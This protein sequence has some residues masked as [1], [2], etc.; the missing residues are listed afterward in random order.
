MTAQAGTIQSTT[1]IRRAARGKRVL[2]R[3][4]LVI[5]KSTTSAVVFSLIFLF[6]MQFH[7]LFLVFALLCATGLVA[8][9]TA[10]RLL[11]AFHGVLQFLVALVALFAAMIA[12]NFYSGGVLGI[13]YLTIYHAEIDLQAFIQ[14]GIGLLAMLLALSAWRKPR[15]RQ[16][17]VEPQSPPRSFRSPEMQLEAQQQPPS[18]RVR[19]T[20]ARRAINWLSAQTSHP[21]VFGGSRRTP[22]P[23]PRDVISPNGRGL[24]LREGTQIRTRRSTLVLRRKKPVKFVGVEEH[25]CPYCL[26]TVAYNDPRGVEICSICHTHHH[27]DCWEVTGVCQVPH[28]NG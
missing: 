18:E 26:E 8:G 22:A 7:P 15:H 11:G 13:D 3:T 21:F 2:F 1:Q 25:R 27:A 12:L 20:P 19:L 16:Q 10:R 5:L 23:P 17:I 6:E 14:V 28:A 24:R 9:V 4:I